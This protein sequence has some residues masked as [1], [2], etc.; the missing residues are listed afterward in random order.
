LAADASTGG[1]IDCG[2]AGPGEKARRSWRRMKVS[3]VKT[4]DI[5][6]AEKDGFFYGGGM[7]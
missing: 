5:A 2:D 6:T 4:E 3:S 1:A 7:R